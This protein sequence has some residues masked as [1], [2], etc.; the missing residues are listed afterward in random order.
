MRETYRTIGILV[1]CL[2]FFIVGCG[3]PEGEFDFAADYRVGPA[4]TNFSDVGQVA[5]I[6][7]D[8]VSRWSRSSRPEV[9][10]L[11]DDY[12]IA[13]S[14]PDTRW[15]FCVLG[16]TWPEWLCEQTTHATGVGWDR[17]SLAIRINV[18]AKEYLIIDVESGQKFVVGE[19]AFHAWSEV[20]HLEML[21]LEDAW[22]HSPV[23]IDTRRTRSGSFAPSE[24][25][26]R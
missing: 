2:P 11:V 20:R 13:R 10:H 8:L 1:V 25:T 26:L 19:Q 17:E 22:R 4:N 24:T 9:R 23:G 6:V 3:T 18:P 12:W 21:E 14:A 16:G 7:R 5:S 15:S